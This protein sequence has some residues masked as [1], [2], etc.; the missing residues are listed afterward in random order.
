VLVLLAAEAMLFAAFIG[1]FLIFKLTAPFWPPLNLPRLPITVT[2]ANT[3]VLL[4][5]GLTM[6]CAVAAA[7]REGLG[8][9]RLWLTVTAALG[10]AFLLVQGHEWLR[11]EAQG[12][13]LTSGNYGAT[14]YVLIGLHGL[15]VACAV[16]WLIGV[17]VVAALD[18]FGTRARNAVE[19][20]AIYWY[21]VCAVWPLLFCLVYF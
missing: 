18:S 4:T 10:A 11:M 8:K 1:A 14:F 13:H 20:C 7:R 9:M 5:S 2:W 16:T 6:R 17:T 19:M 15:H 12:L 3:A 21:F